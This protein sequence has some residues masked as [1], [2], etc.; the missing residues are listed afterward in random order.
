MTNQSQPANPPKIG[1]NRYRRITVTPQ[2]GSIGA[3]LGNV[4][5][6]EDLDDEV[7]G[8]IR[9]ALLDH[10]VIFFDGQAHVTPDQQIAFA[11]RFGDLVPY[12]MVKG[13][14]GY[15]E[16]V[17]V[18]KLEHEKHNFGGLWH[19]DTTYMDVPPLGSILLARE[20]PPYGGDTLFA[21]MYLAYET[22]SAPLREMLDKLTVIQ[23]SG[24]GAVAQSRK[25]RIEEEGRDAKT[26]PVYVAEHPAVRT[27]PETGRKALYVNSGHSIGFKELTEEESRPLLDFLFAHQTRP[28]F[29]CRFVWREGAAA[30]WDNRASQHNPINDYHGFKRV[31]H[32]VTI[33]GDKPF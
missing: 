13:L 22:L 23:S 21:N 1:D 11:R 2:S 10:L 6:A 17:P 3:L 16:I 32:R 25:A 19:T 33:A 28:E 20:L 12:P 8:E 27:H 24:K 29:T 7:I 15:P 5:M 26:A 4:D 31:M 30:F 18:V 9:Q 14:E